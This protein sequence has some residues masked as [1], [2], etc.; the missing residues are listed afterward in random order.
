ESDHSKRKALTLTAMS[1]GFV[2]VQLDVTIVNVAVK[3]IGAALGGGVSGLQWVVNAYT[4]SFAALILTAGAAGDRVGSK[5]VFMNGFAIFVAASLGCGLAPNIGLLICARAIQGCGAAILVPCSLALLNHAYPEDQERT[6]A[7][8]IWAAGASVALAAGPVMGGVLIAAIGWRTV[9]F[10]NIPI[11]FFGMWLTRR[12]VAETP[13]TRTRGLDY[14][15]QVLAILWLAVMAAAIIEAGRV[16]WTNRWI[17][18]GFAVV[19]VTLLAFVVV[20]HKGRD[21]MMP[22]SLFRDRTFTASTAIGLLIN[23]AYYGLIFVLSLYFQEIRNY[24]ALHTGLAFLP[25]T[26]I[27]LAANLSAGYFSSRIG[28]RLTMF[29]GQALFAIGAFFLL[30]V[31]S[32]GSYLD[33]AFQLLIIGA[34][35]GITVPPMTSELLGTVDKKDSGIASGVLNSARQAGSVVGVALLG[36]FVA[37]K[38]QF[39]QG[40]H[41]GL[42]FSVVAVAAGGLV[43]LIV[44]TK[45]TSRSRAGAYE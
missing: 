31:G 38:S 16:G 43:S 41:K 15:G 29:V 30:W 1:L 24:T 37:Q 10:I 21:P 40:F 35:I 8:G 19:F 36:S 26:A 32:T 9:F 17:I 39:I 2:V 28:S 7:I 6:R 34:G 11:G 25:M 44:E 14:G 22:L 4:I 42:V 33:L 3:S 27:V 12:F 13:R 45:Q 18:S 20:E 5:R 23:V